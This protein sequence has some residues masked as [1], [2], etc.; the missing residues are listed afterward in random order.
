ED[1]VIAHGYEEVEPE[2]PEVGQAAEQQALEDYT[3]LLRNVLQGTGALEAHTYI[4]SNQEKLFDR[5]EV[6]RGDVAEMS[7]ALTEDYTAV[8]NWL[9][10]SLV[11]VL[12]RNRH[13]AYPQKFYEVAD[14]AVL[15][16]SDTGASNRRKL[17]YV[18]SGNGVDYN[19]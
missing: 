14:V 3:G 7:N 8:R 17:A 19:D 1:A 6:P 12:K 18:Q 10:P 16:D 2:V 4:L 5:M 15:D 13:R 11:E 9:L